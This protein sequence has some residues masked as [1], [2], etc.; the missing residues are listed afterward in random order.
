MI[1]SRSRRYD[2]GQ[3]TVEFALL[4][5]LIILLMVAMVDVCMV[6]RDQLLADDLARDAARR[7]SVS[8]SEAAARDAVADV[9][10]TSGR[11]DA[12]WQLAIDDDTVVVRVSLAPRMSPLLSTTLWFSRQQR[13]SGEATFATEF[14][15]QDR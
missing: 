14:H 6:L 8:E 3:A 5:P 4:L 12:R 1:P 15:I 2:A 10:I 7:A 13:V 9:V 11:D